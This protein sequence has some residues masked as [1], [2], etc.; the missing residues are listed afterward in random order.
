MCQVSTVYFI[1]WPFNAAIR[2]GWSFGT[3]ATLEPVSNIDYCFWGNNWLVIVIDV[4]T[5]QMFADTIWL[6]QLGHSWVRHWGSLIISFNAPGGDYKH[7]HSF[8]TPQINWFGKTR[9]ILSDNLLRDSMNLR[10]IN[11]MIWYFKT[12]RNK[13]RSILG[14]QPRHAGDG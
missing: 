12:K 8:S 14:H 7:L 13:I 9:K 1:K 6:Q 5:A 11:S 2:H 4:Q 3:E 10:N